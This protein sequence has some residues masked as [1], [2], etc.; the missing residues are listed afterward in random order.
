M[1]VAVAGGHGKVGVRV[2]ARLVAAGHEARG[3]VRRPEQTH[4]LSVVGARPVLA[5][6]EDGSTLD[7]AVAG[8]DA[9]VFAA[10]A[11]AGSGPERKRTV[12]LGGAVRLIE[13]AQAAQIKR[14]VMVSSVGAQDPEA[15]SE[16]M[17]P[18]LRAKAEA[19]AALAAS[20]LDWTIVRPGRLTDDPAT[21]L[22]EATTQLGQRKDVTRNDVAAAIL[23]VLAAPHTVGLTF[24]LFNGDVPVADAIAALRP[25]G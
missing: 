14:Y 4:I 3:L 7:A 17:R 6:L 8:A 16:A 23:A 21:G 12:D 5:D 25:P 11:G 18:Y 19:D 22:V 20:G 13:A 2:L 9:V 10:G 15:G 1:I 24:E